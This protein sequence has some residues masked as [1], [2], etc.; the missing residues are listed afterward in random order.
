MIDTLRPSTLGEILDRTAQIYRSRF[1]VFLG[2]AAMPA[3]G[4]LA[5]APGMVW[6]VIFT[7]AIGLVMAGRSISGADAAG[8]AVVLLG[9]VGLMLYALWMLLLLCL[10][11]PASVVENVGPGKALKRAIFLSKGTRG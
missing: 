3:G 5:V 4:I 9:L 10:A 2:I 11:F 6:T 1:L 7:F 8:G